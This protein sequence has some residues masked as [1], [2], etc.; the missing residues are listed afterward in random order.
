MGLYKIE[1][2]TGECLFEMTKDVLLRLEMV[3]S[4]CRVQSYDGAGSMKG[5]VKGLKTRILEI[6]K[7]ALYI[8]CNGHLLN[9]TCGELIKLIKMLKDALSYAYEIIKLTRKS[10]RRDAIFHRILQELGEVDTKIIAMFPKINH[11]Y[12]EKPENFGANF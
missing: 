10:T 12:F 7:R 6:E 5:P 4:L 11:F 9:L 3:F 8:H 1:S 2:T